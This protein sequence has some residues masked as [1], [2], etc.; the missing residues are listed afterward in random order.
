MF[1]I[2]CKV[3]KHQQIDEH[4]NV[5]PSDVPFNKLSDGQVLSTEGAS[6]RYFHRQHLIKNSV[7]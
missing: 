4:G 7:I 5:V 3:W 1:V 6:L 2:D